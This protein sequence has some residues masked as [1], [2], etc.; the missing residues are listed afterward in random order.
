MTKKQVGLFALSFAAA[1]FVLSLFAAAAAF[2]IQP[3]APPQEPPALEGDAVFL[4][5]E[6]DALTL[7]LL[8]LQ[9]DGSLDLCLLLRFD[10][11]KGQ[12]PL[13][14]FS[15]ETAVTHR[16][17]A[18]LLGEAYRCGG[19][20]SAREALEETLGIGI[21][22]TGT[23]TPQGFL[24]LAELFGEVDYQLPR[25]VTVEE[26]GIRVTASRGW[27]RLSGPL[28]AA[29]LAGGPGESWSQR[30]ALAADVTAEAINQVLARTEEEDWEALFRGSVN[31]METDL[32][33]LDFEARRKS[34][35]F[36][37]ELETQPAVAISLGQA[38][39]A[40]GVLGEEEKALL[41]AFFP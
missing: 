17:R 31:L 4:P 32:S 20:Q 26:G 12:I 1:F 21:Q 11:A 16:G 9:E 35:A 8:G 37:A 28:A 24:G 29:L 14:A 39:L 40:S 30:C 6:E 38:F 36:L 41:Q 3:Y 33:Y 10:P 27:Q 19:S 18:C 13:A 23:V 22:R 2:T 34:L 15:G 7:L 5:R 25:D